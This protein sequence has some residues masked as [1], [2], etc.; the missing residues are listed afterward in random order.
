MPGARGVFSSGVEA[1]GW[2]PPARAISRIIAIGLLCSTVPGIA[3]EPESDLPNR[4]DLSLEEAVFL[5][6]GNNRELI[7]A[8]L[9]RVVERFSLRVAENKFRPHVEIGSHLDR[10][11]TAPSMDLV[12]TGVGSTV[13]LRIPTGGQFNLDW[14]GA[15]KGGD[16]PSRSR[17]SNELV[18][19]FTQPLLRG[20][21]IGVNTASVRI[22]QAVEQSNL[23]TLKQTIIDVIT[24]VIKSYRD[25]MQAE[26]R[27]EIRTKS[28]QRAQGL[29]AVNESLV[30]SGRMAER[31]V[32]QT[33][34]DIAGRELQLVAARNS[35][36]AARLALTD[37]LD[38]DSRT[39]IRLTETLSEALAG[40]PEQD[41][42]AGSIETALQ[43][44]PDYR[45]AVLGIE[46]AEAQMEVAESERRWDLSATLSSKLSSLD[47]T[48]GG[49]AGHV[50]GTD[51]G[52]R[53]D[54]RIPIGA[55]ADPRDQKYVQAKT[56]LRKA[57]NNL[58][59]LRQRVDIE[60]SNA[61]REV[62]L[63]HRQV[64]LARS[65]RELVEEKVEVEK[66]KLRLGLSSNFRLV[67]FEDD[68]VT[69]QNSELD[70]IIA[71]RTAVTALD[72]TLGTT[73]ERWN[74]EIRDV[75]REDIQ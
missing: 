36:D 61:L 26:H 52:L 35:L 54:L 10:T 69:A 34:A 39:R 75:D 33:K 9:D 2:P 71:H 32:V 27:V 50:D 44:R 41:G 72:R 25:Y 56:A 23:L 24:S 14:S 57:Q 7:G 38:I 55:A 15:R 46:I 17:Y 58:A 4:L 37:I 28:L 62:E 67:T 31:D 63:S 42:M 47:D 5:A 68:L 51:Y 19:T 1:A 6:I 66:E 30:R 21:G 22:A 29:L 74:I 40:E 65:A 43:Q 45:Q 12:T 16:S 8:R 60:V 64:E 49:A 13:A 59:N 11:H 20:S 53:L 3:A 73:L 48:L 18:F 70:S